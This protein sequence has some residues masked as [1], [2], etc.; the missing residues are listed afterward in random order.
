MT[1]K[2]AA[3]SQTFKEKKALGFC[4]AGR[5]QATDEPITQPH[6]ALWKGPYVAYC[7]HPREDQLHPCQP[8]Q[9]LQPD[10]HRH[11]EPEDDEE[12]A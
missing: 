11:P 3:T 8:D 10:D 7:H 1:V 12:A 6:R 2:Q 4:Y 9:L 5:P